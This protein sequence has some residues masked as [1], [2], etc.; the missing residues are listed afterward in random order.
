MHPS[1]TSRLGLKASL[2]AL[3]WR[4]ALLSFRIHTSHHPPMKNLLFRLFLKDKFLG[5]IAAAVA[6][7]A[8]AYAFT[9][10]PGAPEIEQLLVVSLLQLPDGTELTQAGLTAALTPVILGVINAVVQ[11]VVVRGNN[12]VLTDLKDA[13]VYDGKVDGWLGK[14]AKGAIDSLIKK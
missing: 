3:R 8:A 12:A 7:V 2:V 5:Q 11:E 9:Y 6:S 13:G 14:V 1:L 10:L 4:V